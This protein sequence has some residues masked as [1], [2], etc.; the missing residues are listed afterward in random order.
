VA[1]AGPP[2]LVGFFGRLSA[3]YRCREAA[4]AL[5]AARDVD[6]DVSEGASTRACEA[7]VGTLT[8]AA[9]LLPIVHALCFVK[10][11]TVPEREKERRRVVGWPRAT[12]AAERKVVQEATYRG[13]FFKA[14][15]IRDNVK[16]TYAAQADF[17]KFFQ[18]FEVSPECR[19]YFAVGGGLGLATMPTGGVAP[20]LIA[21]TLTSAVAV[22]AIREAGGLVVYDA[23]IDNVRF[24]SDDIDA[25]M[26][27]WNCFMTK[28]HSIGIVIGEASTVDDIRDRR[29]YTYLGMVFDHVH[30]RVSQTPKTVRKLQHM[31]DVFFDGTQRKILDIMCVFSTCLWASTVVDWRLAKVYHVF[32]QLRRLARAQHKGA[33]VAVVWPS[34][35]PL[36]RSWLQEL[37]A[38]EARF[39]YV[40]T[41]ANPI[42]AYSD[43]CLDGWGATVFN[44]AHVDILG[45]RWTKHERRL[46]INVLEVLAVKRFLEQWQPPEQTPEER[47]AIRLLLDNTSA[48]AWLKRRRS[49]TFTANGIVADIL[50]ILESKGLAIVSTT[51]VPSARNLADAPSRG[52]FATPASDMLQW[53]T[54]L[55][56]DNAWDASPEKGKRVVERRHTGAIPI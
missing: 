49:A 22:L 8:A 45:S 56:E 23:N 42:L 7:D 44:A 41:T 6:L 36:W 40:S 24:L 18:L 39:V 21:H 31:H 47:T 34:I 50:E 11:F 10:L 51:Y 1:Q 52:D 20:P 15:E 5:Y 29:P 38:E 14:A 35:V 48:I 19:C 13:R 43:A 17:K 33:T 30:R 4:A 54:A 12:N 9:F 26:R 53:H 2:E 37:A 46:H 25:L 27:V 55:T 3:P 16:Y 32:K 28:C